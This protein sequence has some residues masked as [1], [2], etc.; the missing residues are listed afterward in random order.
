ML[1]IITRSQ[2]KFIVFKE[3]KGFKQKLLMGPGVVQL[4][5]IINLIH[6]TFR[7]SSGL[8]EIKMSD[9]TYNIMEF[10]MAPS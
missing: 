1:K 7:K 3:K 2:F 10:S 4:R 6:S 5:N 8:K 9:Y